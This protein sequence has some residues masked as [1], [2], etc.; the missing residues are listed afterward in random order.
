VADACGRMQ[1]GER[2][3]KYGAKT[4]SN[5][6]KQMR[7]Q[8]LLQLLQS[9]LHLHFGDVD[10]DPA[11][12]GDGLSQVTFVHEY[13]TSNTDAHRIARSSLYNGEGRHVWFLSPSC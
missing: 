5:C 3:T 9:R 13:R 10:A 8:H 7:L 6:K 11:A 2:T 4:A 12:A 1:Q